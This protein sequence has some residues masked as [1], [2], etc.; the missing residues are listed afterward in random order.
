MSDRSLSEPLAEPAVGAELSIPLDELPPGCCGQVTRVDAAD[1]DLHRLQAMGVCQGRRVELVKAGDP[2]ILRV[3]GS[4]LGISARLASMIL[5]E[6][7][8]DPRCDAT[9]DSDEQGR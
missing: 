6:A 4:R 3:Y 5:V 9:N 8:P 2:L 7:C 1:D